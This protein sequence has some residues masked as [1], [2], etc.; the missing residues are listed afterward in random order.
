MNRLLDSSIL[1]SCSAVFDAFDESVMFQ[2]EFHNITT[3]KRQ[4][5]GVFQVAFPFFTPHA[6]AL[7]D[8][9]P[10]ALF[11]R[12]S[13]ACWIACR[14]RSVSCTGSCRCWAWGPPFVCCCCLRTSFPSRGRKLSRSSTH[15]TS[16]AGR[17]IGVRT[18]DVCVCELLLSLGS[19]PFLSWPPR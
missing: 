2:D 3:L 17:Y 14:V 8:V 18:T 1:T 12:I 7:H 13:R 19:A 6:S 11:L 9:P 15:L 4:F 10:L 16:L 5:K